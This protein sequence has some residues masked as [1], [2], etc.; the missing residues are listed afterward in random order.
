MNSVTRFEYD[1]AGRQTKVVLPHGGERRYEY[2]LAG[3]LIRTEG[4]PEGA[5]EYRYDALGRQVEVIDANNRS[6]KTVYDKAGRVVQFVNEMN[7]AVTYTYDRANKRLSLTDAKGNATLFEYDRD[8]KMTRMMYPP[9]A[10]Q[11]DNTEFY[12]YDG[13]GRLTCKTTPKGDDIRFHYDP[14]GNITTLYHG[15]TVPNGQAIPANRLIAKYERNGAGAVTKEEDPL[16]AIIYAY[17]EFGRMVEAKDN[18]LNKAVRYSYDNRGLRNKMSVIDYAVS[19]NGIATMSVAYSYDN[20]GRLASVKKDSDPATVYE[21]DLFGN[22]TKLILPNGVISSYT[23]GANDRLLELATVKGASVLASFAYSLDPAGNRTGITYAD[24]SKSIYAFDNAYRLTQDKRIDSVGQVLYDEHYTYDSADNRLTKI[25][26][27]WNPV[28]V[29]YYY[30]ARNQ[31]VSTTGTETKA[32]DYDANGNTV[33]IAPIS[34]NEAMMY[35]NLNRL[36]HYQGPGG[37]EEVVY[38]GNTWN[39]WRLSEQPPNATSPE[40]TLFLYDKDNVVADYASTTP[41][42]SRLSVPAITMNTKSKLD[43]VIS[44][45]T[46]ILPTPSIGI[47]SK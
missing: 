4:G 3:E 11:S 40:I 30:N 37:I 6:R 16:T 8:G 22:R 20:V 35:D 18:A 21:Y 9:V 47:T 32:Y 34:G 14:S 13:A 42:Q 15:T 41:T 29:Q 28:N 2:N 45:T 23:Y 17:D 26:T 27:G 19:A 12:Q 44:M 24:G 31:L 46:Q 10:G 43:G 1:A 36:I 5:R 25:R 7:Q 39:R 38:R 33:N